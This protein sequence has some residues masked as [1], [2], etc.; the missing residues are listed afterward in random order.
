[1]IGDQTLGQR[2][3]SGALKAVT[4]TVRFR[5]RRKIWR[6]SDRKRHEGR[7]DRRQDNVPASTSSGTLT[8]DISVKES[9]FNIM[10][11]LQH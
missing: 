5:G 7:S 4:S 11:L 3:L 6:Q 9:P 10:L 2:F 8:L 1:M